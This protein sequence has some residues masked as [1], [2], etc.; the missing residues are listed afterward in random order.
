MTAMTA[1]RASTRRARSGAQGGFTLI[2]LLVT[3]TVAAIM[4]GIAVPSFKNFVNGQRVKAASTELMT[5]VLIA[6][7]EAVKRNASTLTI[8]PLSGT[9][10]TTGWTVAVGGTTLHKQEA[11][12]SLTVT[13]YSDSTCAT[14]A[15]VS[16]VTFSNSGR[17]AASSC[18]KFAAASTTTTRCVKVDLTGIPASGS[19]P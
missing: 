10:W 14:T 8:A 1:T 4:L 13:T 3:L 17:T 7:S 11:L 9:D 18:F 15:A 16:G 6:R 19:C 5:A 2:E 12:Q